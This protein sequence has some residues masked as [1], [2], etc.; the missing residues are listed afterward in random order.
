MSEHLECVFVP[1]ELLAVHFAV[2]VHGVDHIAF[3]QGFAIHKL[4]PRTN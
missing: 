2:R 3:V 1:D 4:Q